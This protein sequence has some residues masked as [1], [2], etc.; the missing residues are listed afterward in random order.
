M[1]G[2][3]DLGLELVVDEDPFSVSELVVLDLPLPL[4]WGRALVWGAESWCLFLVFLDVE[5]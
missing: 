5:V 4:L 1:H 3:A 2:D